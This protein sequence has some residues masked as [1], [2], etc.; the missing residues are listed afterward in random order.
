MHL[1]ISF[2]LVKAPWAYHVWQ[3]VANGHGLPKV[4]L[5]PAMPYP[6]TLCSWATPET[7]AAFETFQGWPARRM[8]GLRPFYIPLDTPFRPPV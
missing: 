2:T 7:A 6:S 5:G 8:G 1:E 3:G 4:L